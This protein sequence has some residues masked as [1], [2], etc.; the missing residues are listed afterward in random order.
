MDGR[1]SLNLRINIKHKNN[2]YYNTAKY[3]TQGTDKEW[4]GSNSAST[5]YFFV[6]LTIENNIHMHSDTVL[7]Y[8]SHINFIFL[9]DTKNCPK[10]SEKC[11]Y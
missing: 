9:D 6:L 10:T 1:K 5:T 3:H 11:L 7:S 2:N 8:V 4:V